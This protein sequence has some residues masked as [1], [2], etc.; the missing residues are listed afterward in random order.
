MAS[1]Q[2]FSPALPRRHSLPGYQV[3]S[4]YLAQTSGGHG[5]LTLHSADHPRKDSGLRYHYCLFRLCCQQPRNERPHQPRSLVHPY[6]DAHEMC[7]PGLAPWSFQV[8]QTFDRTCRLMLPASGV[9]LPHQALD[10]SLL[11]A[12][13]SW[14]LPSLPQC[15]SKPSHRV[16]VHCR[17]G[18]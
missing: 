13:Y 7:I 5:T 8:L 11:H 3:F 16:R 4:S 10:L 18:Q 14:I 2:S 15:R 17:L 6:W 1:G 9:F 12:T